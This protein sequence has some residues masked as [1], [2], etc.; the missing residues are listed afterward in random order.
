M[1]M[2]MRWLRMWQARDQRT[3]RVHWETTCHPYHAQGGERESGMFDTTETQARRWARGFVRANP[4]GSVHIQ[5]V[6]A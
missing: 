6:D 4:M 1:T 5:P 2:F 3:V